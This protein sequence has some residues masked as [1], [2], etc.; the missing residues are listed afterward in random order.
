VEFLSLIWNEGIIRPMVNSLVVIYLLLFQSFGLSILVFTATVRL[1]TFPLTVKQLRQTRAMSQLAPRIQ[2]I[3]KKHA[4]DR[5]K[6]SQETFRLYKEHGVNPVGCLGPLVVQMPILIG[7]YW[8]LIRVLPSNP[9]N[10]VELSQLLYSWLPAVHQSIPI[11]SLFLTVDLSA[12]VGNLV[13][14][15][16]FLVTLLVGGSMWVQQKMATMPSADARQQSTQRMMLWM[17]PIMFAV[18]TWSFPSGLALYWISSNLIGI[19]IQ[20][21]IT[22]LGGLRRQGPVAPA[23]PPLP[24]PE[25]IAPPAPV[26][27]HEDDKQHSHDSQERRRSRGAGAQR[28]RRRPRGG[29]G[30]GR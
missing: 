18:I 26:E 10:L 11:N 4:G 12:F 16:N 15:V 8:A 29:R 30:R 7:L 19:A 24:T 23:A 21:K 17:F 22:G 20:F 2:E 3:Q 14:P 5:Q 28:A 6:V 13:S 25:P 9:E 27:E 1:L